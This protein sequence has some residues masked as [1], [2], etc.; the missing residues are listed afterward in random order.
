[1]KRII[2][3]VVSVLVVGVI[4]AQG[5]HGRFNPEHFNAELEQYITRE[6]CLT[7]KEASDFFPLYKEL[8]QK[9]RALYN[10]MARQRSVKPINEKGC[11]EAIVKRDD[12]EVQIKLLLQQY[13]IKFM[14]VLP[15]AK[16]YDV[17]Q[18]EDRFHREWFKRMAKNG[19]PPGRIAGH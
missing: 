5:L 17:M 16:V 4:Q 9:Q 3:L 15:A 6:A 7:P 19:R 10:T 2:T 1:M 8:M 11:R 13:H 18:A 12:I 14:E